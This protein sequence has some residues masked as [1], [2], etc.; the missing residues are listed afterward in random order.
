MSRRKEMDMNDTIRM[1]LEACAP[2]LGALIMALTGV[3]INYL[4]KRS[5]QTVATTD[6]QLAVKYTN[7]ITETITKCVLAVSQ[8]YVDDLKKKGAFTKEAQQEAFKRC[9]DAVVDMLSEEAKKY[10][11]ATY[12][13]LNTYLTSAIEASVKVNKTA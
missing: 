2:A 1:I 11:T 6:N 3:L 8:T 13:D 5:K 10:I 4:Q 12:G 7:M 9:Y